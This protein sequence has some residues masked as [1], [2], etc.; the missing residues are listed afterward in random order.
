MMM[1]TTGVMFLLLMLEVL[2]LTAMA[3]FLRRSARARQAYLGGCIKKIGPLKMNSH[4]KDFDVV[5]AFIRTRKRGYSEIRAT[6]FGEAARRLSL[7][8]AASP[9]RLRGQRIRVRGHVMIEPHGENEGRDAKRLLVFARS[10]SLPGLNRGPRRQPVL[11][12]RDATTRAEMTAHAPG[13]KI[14]GGLH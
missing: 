5:V 12:A 13:L 7:A 10:F 4:D 11:Q 1:M 6:L 2:A 14:V 8:A 3:L 9:D